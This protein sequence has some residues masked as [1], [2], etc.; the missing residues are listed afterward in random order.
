MNWEWWL[1]IT[2]RKETTVYCVVKHVSY[3]MWVLWR[4]T[5]PCYLVYGLCRYAIPEHGGG[6]CFLMSYLTGIIIFVFCIAVF[7][8]V[9]TVS[10]LKFH[11]CIKEVDHVTEPR[12]SQDMSLQD[13]F[14]GLRESLNVLA[15]ERRIATSPTAKQRMQTTVRKIQRAATTIGLLADLD[16]EKL[17]DDD[18]HAKPKPIQRTQSDTTLGRLGRCTETS[19]DARET[20]P[21]GTPQHMLTVSV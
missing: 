10:L 14:S 3:C 1:E 2:N 6:G 21:V 8:M 7:T 17:E 16:Q 20:T 18:I 19:G 12:S 4:V 5:L 15:W 9:M 11:G 13:T